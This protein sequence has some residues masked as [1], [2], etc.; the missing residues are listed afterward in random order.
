MKNILNIVG[1]N[2]NA[3]LHITL[4]IN[5]LMN[6]EVQITDLVICKLLLQNIEEYRSYSHGLQQLLN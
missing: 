3:L 1:L 2:K 5:K 4:S 6:G